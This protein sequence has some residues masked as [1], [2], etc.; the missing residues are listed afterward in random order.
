[1]EKFTIKRKI[2]VEEEV[3]YN[4][5]VALKIEELRKAHK[6]TQEELALKLGLTRTSVINM[7]KGRQNLSIKNLYQICK[8]FNIKSSQILPF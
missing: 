1:M 3:T 7:E 4:K 5:Y 2:V 8:I 6:L